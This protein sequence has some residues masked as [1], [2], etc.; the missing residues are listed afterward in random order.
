M[1]YRRLD[2][3]K[4]IETIELLGLRISERFPASGLSRVCDEL[5][6]LARESTG[7]IR[8]I[9]RPF[10]GLRILVTLVVLLAVISIGY[11]ISL[12]Q[13]SMERITLI[14]IIQASEASVNEIVLIGAA[15]YFLFQLENRLKRKRCLQ[16]LHELRALAHVIDMHQLTK[17]PAS[18]REKSTAHS[19]RREMTNFELKRYLDYCSEMLALTSKIAALYANDY[20]DEVVLNTINEIEELT[21]SLSRKV[22][23]KIVMIKD[24]E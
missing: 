12:L 8:R 19:P 1:T 4:T 7:N 24:E 17:D 23:Q 18:V 6:T 13:I 2:V 9:T 3:R 21:S 14:D 16:S 5:L 11:S 20:K 22:W 15:V 10:V